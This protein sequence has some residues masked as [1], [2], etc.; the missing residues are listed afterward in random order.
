MVNWQRVLPKTGTDIAATVFT[1]FGIN[2][3]FW[4]EILYVKS[5]ILNDYPNYPSS[6][7]YLH[8]FL[9]CL[10]YFNSLSSMLLTI[11]TDASTR[12]MMLPTY[13]KPGDATFVINNEILKSG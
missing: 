2:L 7:L 9:G 12:G 1:F 10:I 11:I 8:L 4:F 13:T 5:E 6:L 3:I